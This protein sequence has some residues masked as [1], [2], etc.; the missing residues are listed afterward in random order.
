MYINEIKW[1]TNVILIYKCCILFVD[2][3]YSVLGNILES[4]STLQV[5][6]F[7]TKLTIYGQVILSLPHPS[8]Q[9]SEDVHVDLCV[10]LCF[11]LAQNNLQGNSYIELQSNEDQIKVQPQYLW[12]YTCM[13]QH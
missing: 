6:F 4:G 9:Y 10:L 1:L 13:C 7:V 11:T 5:L 3:R 2:T 12:K 8:L